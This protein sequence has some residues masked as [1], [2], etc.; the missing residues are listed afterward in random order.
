VRPDCGGPRLNLIEAAPLVFVVAEKVRA[1]IALSATAAPGWFDVKPIVKNP[2]SS[3]SPTNTRH[4]ATVV[5]SLTVVGGVVVMSAMVVDVV[6]VVDTVDVTIA[7]EGTDATLDV[8]GDG[9]DDAGD[10]WE[11]ERAAPPQPIKPTHEHSR[12]TATSRCRMRSRRTVSCSLSASGPT[13]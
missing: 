10:S 1:L 11:A 6:D 13:R 9:I 12:R 3:G 5:V 8:T 4:V 2:F 7:V